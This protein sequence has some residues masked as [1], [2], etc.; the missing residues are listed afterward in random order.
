[1]QKIRFSGEQTSRFAVPFPAE[2]V[3]AS[4]LEL[5]LVVLPLCQRR[6]R[7]DLAYP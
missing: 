2:E 3:G 7:A 6:R 1:M 4:E 5:L